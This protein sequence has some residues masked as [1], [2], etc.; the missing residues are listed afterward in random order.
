M[1]GQQFFANEEMRPVTC[2]GYGTHQ[3]APHLQLLEEFLYHLN[4]NEI[5]WQGAGIQGAGG[6][7][8]LRGMRH[9]GYPDVQAFFT[10]CSD[11]ATRAH[12]AANVLEGR[13]ND[14]V[15]EKMYALIPA[16]YRCDQRVNVRGAPDGDDTP[17]PDG[18]DACVAMAAVCG[19]PR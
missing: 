11:R 15:C 12:V 19:A 7:G 13:L 3:W 8:G 17:N 14:C 18:R 9:S 6:G 16:S 2:G 10:T 5:M 4:I 1:V